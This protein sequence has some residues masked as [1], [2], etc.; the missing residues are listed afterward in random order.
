MIPCSWA[1]K[2]PLDCVGGALL[3]SSNKVK[4]VKFSH[5][6][7]QVLSPELIP[8]YRQSVL[9]WLLKS[10]PAV[11]CH[12]FP[13]SLQSPSE[14]KNVTVLRPVPSYTAWWQRYIGVNNL[15]KVVMQLCFGGNWTH[16]LLITIPMSYHYSTVP[17]PGNEA[18][19]QWVNDVIVCV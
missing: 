10:F 12:Y 17:L 3:D 6:R 19:H 1:V 16:D 11:G 18:L 9:R 13:P 8:V 4:K 15:S 5:T 7:Y 14:P 2:V